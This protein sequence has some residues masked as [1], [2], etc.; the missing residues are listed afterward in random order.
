MSQ[1]RSTAN[2]YLANFRP[3]E[4]KYAERDIIQ[5]EITDTH[6]PF[7]TGPNQRHLNLKKDPIEFDAPNNLD[8]DEGLADFQKANMQSVGAKDHY[9]MHKQPISDEDYQFQSSNLK[10]RSS[11]LGRGS[12][13]QLNSK[14]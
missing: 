7:V 1:R 9:E 8:E 3:P 2:I 5:K 14:K 12:S 4:S 6:N 11:K 13:S 10:S